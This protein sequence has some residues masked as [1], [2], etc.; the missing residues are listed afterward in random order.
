MIRITIVALA[1]HCLAVISLAE[2]LPAV[3]EGFVVEIVA[4]EPM[5]SNPCVMAFD[6]LGR[7]CVAQGPQW[8]GPTPDTPGD[9]VD[10]LIDDD[11]DGIAD[12]RKTFAEGFNSVQGIAWH[13]SDLWVANAPDL[14]VVRDTNGDDE[15]DVYIRVYTGLGNLEHSLHGLNFG[16]D[17]KLYMS[18]GNSKGYNRPDQLAPKSF[19]ELW[20]VPSP[21]GAPDYTPVE[22]FIKETYK[23]K[24]HTPQDDWGQQG[25]ILRC[26]PYKDDQVSGRN[27]EIISRGFRNPWDI[28]FDD[29]FNWL[30]T[31]NDQSA[32][33]RIFMPFKHAHFGWGHLWSFSWTGE[34]HLPTVP[35]SA[36]LFEG[37]GTGVTHYHA[38]QF[39]PGY[40]DAFFIGDWLKREVVLFRPRWDG[41]L[42]IADEGSPTVFARAESGRTLP[43]SEGQVFDPTDLEVGPDGALYVL[44]WGHGYG[45]NLKNGKQTDAGRVYRIRYASNELTQ[46]KSEHRSKPINTWSFEQLFDDLGSHIAAWRV[47][48]QQELLRRGPSSAKYI[49]DQLQNH[50]SLSKTQQT[51]AIW[52]LGRLDGAESLLNLDGDLNQQIQ[53]LRVLSHQIQEDRAEINE[54]F[55]QVVLAALKSREARLRFEAVQAVGNAKATGMTTQVVEHL[56]RETDRVT[57]YA[58]WNVLRELVGDEQRLELMKKSSGRVRLG[59]LLGLLADDA[60]SAEQV[61]AL[62]DDSHPQVSAIAEQWL[63]KTGVSIPLVTLSPEPGEFTDQVTVSLTTTLPGHRITYT[64]DGSIP[65]GTSTQYR[66]PIRLNQ[67]T[68]LKVAALK[69]NDLAGRVVSGEY[70]IAPTPKYPGHRFIRDIYTPSGR[71]YEMDYRGLAIGKLIYTDRDY[72]IKNLPAQLQNAAYL[73]V[74]N[75]D[76]RSSGEKWLSLKPM[77]MRMFWSVSICETTHR[78]TG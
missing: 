76:D 27:L 74:A 45:G 37:S 23:R 53:V 70:S 19:R 66:T 55:T 72:T 24:Y 25:G 7:I 38:S 39:P 14:T 75:N 78:C 13:G 26:D 36:P 64:T 21:V 67:T 2:E 28:A 52:T 60:V 47:N 63:I 46:W 49:G 35:N 44:S 61:K 6:R 34:D 9:R 41:A 42:M 3:P 31:D 65:A 12:G 29:G 33:D 1:W 77:S 56:S 71:E 58:A 50:E 62:Q 30:G 43:S 40:R 16:P 5:V 8:R 57:F 32:G 18:K 10:I 48:A 68:I 69:G 11:R 15:A 4:K 73:R 17:G 22:T 20:G 51:W 59:L 54:E